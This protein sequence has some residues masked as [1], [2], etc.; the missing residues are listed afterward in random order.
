MEKSPL[1]EHIRK[2][3]SSL[4]T[5]NQ[6]YKLPLILLVLMLPVT[7]LAGGYW[8]FSDLS[9]NLQMVSG[10]E[11][12]S[13]EEGQIIVRLTDND[14]SSIVGASC[15]T[16][17]LYPDKA[18]FISDAAMLSSTEIGNYYYKFTPPSETGIYEYTIKCNI[19]QN[20]KTTTSTVSHSFH[21]SPA[22]MQL[23]SELNATRAQLEST[24]AELIG[25]MGDI[26]ESIEHTVE[27][28]INEE[29]E[30]RNQRMADWAQS[31]NNI[32]SEPI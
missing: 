31:M 11:Y 14:G 8:Y 9:V 21:V 3:S 13:G 18:F 15:R 32:F 27:S 1:K 16:N 30:E 6:S 5:L 23:I 2:V 22:L 7:V 28:K 20:S 24:R 12:I 29:A 26:N 17:I 10:T 4:S 19:V 25:Y